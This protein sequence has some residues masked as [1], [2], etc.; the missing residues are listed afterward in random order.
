M[1]SSKYGVNFVH[2]HAAFMFIYNITSKISNAILKDWIV[3]QKEEHI[4]EIMATKLFD[5]FKFYRLLDQ[6]ETDGATYV[7][8]YFT[9]NKKRYEKYITEMAPSLKEKAFKKWGDQF[10]SF[11]SL[12]QSV[13]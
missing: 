13:Q 9:S 2:N 11:R 3:W 1:A 4:P 8:Q 10:L 5:D 7:I 12:L 6:D